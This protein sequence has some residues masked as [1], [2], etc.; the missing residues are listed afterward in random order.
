MSKPASP[1]IGVCKFKREGHCIGCSMTRDQKSMFKALKKEKHRRAFV[2]MLVGQQSRM[3]RYRHWVP[4]YLRKCL[5]KKVK[6]IAE[7]KDVA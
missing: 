2:Q 1:C 3:G 7:L 4:Q 6:P 5:K